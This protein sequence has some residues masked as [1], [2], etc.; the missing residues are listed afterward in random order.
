[1]WTFTQFS[2]Q[3]YVALDFLPLKFAEFKNGL[4]NKLDEHLYDYLHL[5]NICC[6]FRSTRVQNT[7]NSDMLNY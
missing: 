6:I 4:Q 3:Y 2:K 1:M 5:L 7:L